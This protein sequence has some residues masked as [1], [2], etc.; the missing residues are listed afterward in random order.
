MINIGSI[1]TIAVM[2]NKVSIS[3][4]NLYGISAKGPSSFNDEVGSGAE[5]GKQ[6][7]LNFISEA[8]KKG[9]DLGQDLYGVSWPADDQTPP[10]EI[11][12]F[13]GFVSDLEVEGFEKLELIGGNYFQ[14]N[15]EVLANEIDKGFQDAYMNAMPASGL[16]NRE[17]QHIE[18]Y[19]QEYDPDSEIARFRILI[20]VE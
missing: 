7:W 11:Y 20:P 17:G 5:F 10:Q 16:K 13:C 18:I 6:V 19:G 4:K 1:S 2:T 12:Y 3:P 14:Y 15:C 9:I 8:L